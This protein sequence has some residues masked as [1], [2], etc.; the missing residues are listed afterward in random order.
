MVV[1]DW[2]NGEGVIISGGRE[3]HYL[4]T[5]C[6]WCKGSGIKEDPEHP[7]W[8]R[9]VPPRGMTY[10]T[11]FCKADCIMKGHGKCIPERCFFF[12]PS[13]YNVLSEVEQQLYDNY[14]EFETKRRG[15]DLSLRFTLM[16]MSPELCLVSCDDETYVT[17]VPEG[18]QM[19]YNFMQFKKEES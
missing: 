7:T 11:Y 9:S 15:D 4:E 5:L 14:I 6:A 10:G 18:D 3:V 19:V 12:I 16:L 13:K 1:C 8:G 17:L 2:C